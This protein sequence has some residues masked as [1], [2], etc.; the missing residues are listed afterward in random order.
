MAVMRKL[1]NRFKRNTRGSVA[2]LAGLSAVPLLLAAGVAVDMARASHE[3]EAFQSAVDSS[4]LA[5]AASDLSDLGG[6]TQAQM[7][8]RMALLN[9]LAK[10]YINANYT[11]HFHDDTQIQVNVTVAN[12][13]TVRVE[14]YHDFPTAIMRIVGINEI[15]IGAHAQ[16]KKSA[17]LSENIE[18][19]LVMDTTGSMSQNNKLVDSKAAAK[20]L[21]TEVLGAKQTDPH[22]KFALVPFSGSVS[23]GTQTAP[24][25]SWVDS[26]G[27]ASV[28]KVNFTSATYHNMKGWNDLKYKNALNQTVQLPWNGCLETRLG[29]Y[30]TDDTAPNVAVPDTLF[31]PYFAPDESSKGTISYPNSDYILTSGT[32]NELTSSPS[33]LPSSSSDSVRQKNQAKYLNKVLA[34]VA[35]TA[36]GPWYNC[37]AS[38]IVPLTASRATIEAGI[39]AMTAVGNTVLPEGLAW[40]WRVMSPT[41]P[42]TE[43]AAYNNKQWRKVVIFMTDGQNDVSAGTNTLNGSVYTSYGYVTAPLAKNRFGT[44]SSSGA[45]TALD[46][47]LLTVC[48][49]IKS[50]AEMRPNPKNQSQNIPSIELYT[51]GFQAPVVSTNLLKSCAT[52]PDHYYVNAANGQ[53]LK[54]AF[55]AIGERLKSMYLSE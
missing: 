23:I 25:P 16:V 20:L 13:G 9:D 33:N 44:T 30:G 19:I 54:D 27:L 48:S 6:V 52:D 12:D 39:D 37:V 1:L 24:Y 51:I 29:A 21:F 35:L 4:A 38:A 14:G 40:G 50:K 11:P 55:K 43:G 36:D 26:T 2:L 47:K 15:D 18:I 45:I 42:Y 8:A 5:V 3:D 46:N 31:T 28:S 7:P 17:G 53:E 41:M 49:G 32:P 10:K 34:S 22:L